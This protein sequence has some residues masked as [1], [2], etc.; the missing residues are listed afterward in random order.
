MAAEWSK[1]LRLIG[2]VLLIFACLETIAMTI[3]VEGAVVVECGRETAMPPTP[4][5]EML[6]QILGASAS[7]ILLNY[8]NDYVR[9][10]S[11]KFT[12]ADLKRLFLGMVVSG[13]SVYDRG[14]KYCIRFYGKDYT[15]HKVFSGLAYELYQASPSTLHISDRNTYVTQLYCKDAVVEIKELSPETNQRKGGAPTIAYITEGD[16]SVRE[17]SIRVIMSVSGWINLSFRHGPHGFVVYP[18]LGLGASIPARLCEEYQILTESLSLNFK[19]YADKRYKGTSYLM[20]CSNEVCRRFLELG[21]FLDGNTIKKGRFA[22]KEK[23]TL[24]RSVLTLGGKTFRSI[25]DAGKAVETAFCNSNFEL[26]ALLGRLIL[27]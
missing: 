5:M 22:G 8:D 1:A 10:V 11:R 25:E 17:E 2:I 13:G 6:G 21:G 19:S 3:S 9:R 7:G 16:R 18:K 23:N 24:L 4:Y 15:L 20:T 26:S 27:G 14:G 12:R